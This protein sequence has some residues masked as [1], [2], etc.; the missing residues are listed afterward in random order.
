MPIQD[1]AKL[2]P[3]LRSGFKRTVNWNKYLPKPELLAQNLNLSHLFYFQVVNRFFVLA[4]ENYAQ[5]TSNKRYYLP[6]EEIKVYNV[7]IDG[8]KLFWSTNKK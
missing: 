4:F 7:M 2:L 5:R 1:D 8:K 3:Q 6:S